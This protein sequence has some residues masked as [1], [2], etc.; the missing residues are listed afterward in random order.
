M[1]LAFLS[2]KNYSEKKVVRKSPKIMAG[3]FIF[4]LPCRLPSRTIKL[5]N[6]GTNNSHVTLLPHTVGRE[7]KKDE[8]VEGEV[9]MYIMG[10]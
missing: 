7:K 9:G 8:G 5:G 4:S 10:D 2:K 1:C 3:L 6:S